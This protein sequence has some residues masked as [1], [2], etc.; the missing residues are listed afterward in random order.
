M[1]KLTYEFVKAQFEKEGY[2]LV[3]KNYEGS[4]QKLEYICSVG[5]EH[6][7]SWD[8]WKAGQRCPYCFGNVKLEI[9]FIKAAFAKEDYQLLAEEYINNSQR[10]E[11]ICLN[12][13]RHSVCWNN[14]LSGC[15]CPYCMGRPIITIDLIRSEL[16]KEGYKLLTKK[17]IN[18][19]TKFDYVCNNG[20]TNSIS[21]THWQQGVRCSKCG[22]SGWENEVKAFIKNL[23]L[24]Y[25]PN[26]RST[27]L[28]PNTN[29]Y[30]ELDIF[31]PDLSKAIECNGVYWHSSEH[32]QELDAI[33]CQLCKDKN[34]NLLVITDNEWSKNVGKCK[35]EIN[36]FINN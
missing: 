7:I 13:H 24:F 15:R 26:D 12:G 36:S 34:I 29:R 10:L 35:Y 23:G 28:N 33:K 4:R 14:W 2:E 6:S 9:D 22:I 30:L 25:V 1:R 32:R 31:L 8:N 19:H 11:Y 5:H 3:T 20:H 18:S 17:Y 27:L 21:W 16:D